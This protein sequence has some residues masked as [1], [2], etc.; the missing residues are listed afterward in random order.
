MKGIFGDPISYLYAGLAT[1][2]LAFS[3]YGLAKLDNSV[4]AEKA[5]VSVEKK[6]LNLSESKYLLDIPIKVGVDDSV[7]KES[8]LRLNLR[9]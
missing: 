3:L 7:E 4:R 6:V 5:R 9:P 8:R 1:A 2:G